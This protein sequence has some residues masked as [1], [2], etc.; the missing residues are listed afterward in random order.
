MADV[1][2]ATAYALA[3]LEIVDSRIAG[4]DISFADTV[5]DNASGSRFVLG[6]EYSSVSAFQPAGRTPGRRAFR[7]QTAGLSPPSTLIAVPVT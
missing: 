4:W 5:A 1:I 7:P 6:T 3:V 2:S